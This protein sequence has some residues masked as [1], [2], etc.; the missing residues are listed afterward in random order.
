MKLVPSRGPTMQCWQEDG[1]ILGFLLRLIEIY[2][3]YISYKEKQWLETDLIIRV[4]GLQS[5]GKRP[6]GCLDSVSASFLL[7]PQLGSSRS[8]AREEP[9]GHLLLWLDRLQFQ[10]CKWLTHSQPLGPTSHGMLC[11]IKEKWHFQNNMISWGPFLPS[12]PL[13]NRCH[14]ADTLK[15]IISGKGLLGF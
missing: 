6:E 5:P 9:C 4:W 8:C 1:A 10:M 7:S 3:H 13:Q 15:G 11:S 12:E 2:L 14:L